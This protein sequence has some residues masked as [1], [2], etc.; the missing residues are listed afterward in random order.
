ME[1]N[2]QRALTLV[3]KHEA[4]EKEVWRAIPEYPG[5]E[6]SSLGRIRSLKRRRVKILSQLDTR[7]GYLRVVVSRGGKMTTPMVHRLVLAAFKGPPP[8]LAHQAAHNNGVR[9]DNKPENLRWATCK[10][11]LSDRIRHGTA[12]RGASN[13]RAVLSEG[14]VD[15]IRR[16]YVPGTGRFNPGNGSKLAARFGVTAQTIRHAAKSVTWAS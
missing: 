3:L 13:P 2:F 6:A 14:A 5:Y 9:T 4:Q 8:T 7:G 10:E 16:N 12:P 1:A 11:N 15:F